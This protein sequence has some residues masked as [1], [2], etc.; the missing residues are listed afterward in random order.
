MMHDEVAHRLR[1]V[2]VS[3]QMAV[4]TDLYS[5]WAAI[6]YIQ[7]WKP[8]NAIQKDIDDRTKRDLKW[9]SGRYELI[10]DGQN[11]AS[12]WAQTIKYSNY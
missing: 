3:D 10:A 7:S 2:L 1:P 9:V 6:C 11:V 5:V 4:V 8:E 12:Q